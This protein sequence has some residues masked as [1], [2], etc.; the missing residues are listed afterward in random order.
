MSY[1]P[2]E[3]SRTF[4]TS[5]QVSAMPLPIDHPQSVCPQSESGIY[6]L[7]V[8]ELVVCLC[9]QKNISDSSIKH[10]VMVPFSSAHIIAGLIMTPLD[11]VHVSSISFSGTAGSP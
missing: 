9:K 4:I 1:A 8:P 2:P 7:E 10:H 6:P 3:W 11:G 5:E